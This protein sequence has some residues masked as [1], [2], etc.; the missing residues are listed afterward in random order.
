MGGGRTKSSPIGPALQLEGGSWRERQH[1]SRKQGRGSIPRCRTQRKCVKHK[2]AGLPAGR[3]RRD[4]LPRSESS[5]L[6]RLRAI[7]VCVMGEEG[8]EATGD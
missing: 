1:I 7:C 8:G 2:V 3:E 6:I 5:L 4:T